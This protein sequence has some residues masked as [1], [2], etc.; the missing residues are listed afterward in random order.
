MRSARR[1]GEEQPRS[2]L[3]DMKG[4]P[5]DSHR[6]NP[7][8]PD[9]KGSRKKQEREEAAPATPESGRSRNAER[10]IQQVLQALPVM[11]GSA[12]GASIALTPPKQFSF[13]PLYGNHPMHFLA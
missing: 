6:C 10:R 5:E 9:A 1:G 12:T 13:I 4:N 11:L 7:D 8:E 3:L 2:G